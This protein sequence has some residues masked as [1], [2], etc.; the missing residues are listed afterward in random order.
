M[1]FE[2]VALR[3]SKAL[4][5][6][7]TSHEVL[8]KRLSDLNQSVT[9]LNQTPQI[10]QFFSS[11]Q[12]SREEKKEVLKKGLGKNF[13][14][15]LLSFFSFLF[16][17]D[18]FAYLPEIVKAYEQMAMKELETLQGHLMTAIPID[19]A[20][21]EK[22]K[23][24]LEKVYRKKVVISEEIDPQLIGG[25]ILSMD[26]QQIDF[27]IKGKLEKLKENLLSMNMQE[28]SQNAIET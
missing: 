17:K 23:Q 16:E 6:L 27:S 1:I 14:S 22:L 21:M 19:P 24:K 15:H 12:I 3:Y 28:R 18:R 20:L 8:K 9:V 10:I 2:E 5:N 13:D 11:P 7:D 4:F 26:N 25:G